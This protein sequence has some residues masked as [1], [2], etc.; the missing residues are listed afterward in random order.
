MSIHIF[1]KAFLKKQ[2]IY[3]FN[4]GNNY[5]DFTYVDDIVNQFIFV[6]KKRQKKRNFLMFLISVDKVR[7]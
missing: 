2:T 1:F 4:K 6:S 7:F 3:L 5:R